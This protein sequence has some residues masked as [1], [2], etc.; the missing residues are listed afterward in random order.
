MTLSHWQRSEQGTSVNCD[1]AV[2]GGGIVGTSSAYWIKKLGRQKRIALVEAKTIGYGASGR[3]AGFLLQGAAVDYATD[4]EKYGIENA[5][6]LWSFSQEN[7]DLIA[8][9]LDP[10]K[11]RFEGGGSL[12]LAGSDAEDARLQKSAA[13]L[14]GL[15]K[16]VTYWSAQE[17][18]QKVKG[19]GFEGGL[20]VGSGARVHSQKLVREI[21]GLSG[22]I[23]L[24]NHP[25][26]AVEQHA[27]GVKL[28][29]PSRTIIAEQ[30]IFC[31]NAYLPQ[32]FP[33]TSAYV[34]PVRAQMLATN[35]QPNWLDYPVYS[36]EGF[37][38]VRQLKTGAILV[39]GARH[40]FAEEEVGYE[41][42]TTS[43]LQGALKDYLMRSFPHLGNIIS[44][45]A[46]SGTMGFTSDGLPVISPLSS[47]PGCYWAAGF[48]GHGMGYGFRFGKLVAEVLN[49]R[50]D[51]DPYHHMFDVKRFT[52]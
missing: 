24:E 35:P 8:S 26:F 38:Y 13:L 27:Q 5:R 23:I 44:D 22:A 41:D 15:G 2:V 51:E 52:K 12:I 42:L 50:I 19:D 47:L 9:E 16:N 17:I 11:I 30:V 10:A 49:D 45:Y 1:I 39:G 43:G 28:I 7:R 29:T 40:L 46:W 25:V 37:Y 3:N 48:N 20:Y 31:L 32:L 14:Q 33:E 4:I 6:L 34:R 36:H 21:A 18:R